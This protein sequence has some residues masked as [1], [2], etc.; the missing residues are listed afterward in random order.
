[1]TIQKASISRT[2][3]IIALVLSLLLTFAWL[4]FIFSNS[5][6]SGG[7]SGEQSSK[8]HQIV[9]QVAGSL[10]AKEA[11]SEDTVR[12]GAHFTEFAILG[13]L[14]CLSI[15]ALWRLC[16]V[17]Q[18]PKLMGVACLSL[19]LCAIF[20]AVDEF[21]QTF[22]EGR[23]AQFSDGLLDTAG[24]LAGI[25]SFIGIVGF[26]WWLRR[27]RQKGKRHEYFPRNDKR[28]E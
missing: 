9:N 18:L 5:L 20:A 24:S 21:L 23:S 6:K 13:F 12:S 10:G 2:I 4:G 11:I 17:S 14:C 1:M 3:Q 25:T 16:G 22:S 15:G 8:V 28:A 7:E 19:P 27:R 26:V